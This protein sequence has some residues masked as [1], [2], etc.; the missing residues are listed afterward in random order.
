MTV[1]ELI[2]Q[3]KD[4]PQDAIVWAKAGGEYEWGSGKVDD[5]ALA[6]DGVVWI[7]ARY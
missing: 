4:M 3:L 5:T 1:A 6:M 2:E 7:E